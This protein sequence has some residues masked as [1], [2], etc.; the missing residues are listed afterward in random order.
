MR[1]ARPVARLI[2]LGIDT[3]RELYSL[4]RHK[5]YSQMLLYLKARRSLL[6]FTS[7]NRRALP[8]SNF[9]YMQ[10]K[11]SKSIVIMTLLGP[12]KIE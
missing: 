12:Y 8:V 6:V 9:M 10:D 11:K 3:R 1:T 4:P 7:K 2:E 5:Y